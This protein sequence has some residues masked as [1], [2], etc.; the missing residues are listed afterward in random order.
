MVDSSGFPALVELILEIQMEFRHMRVI[1][2]QEVSLGDT[3]LSINPLVFG[4]LPLGPLQAALSPDAGGRIILHALERGVNLLDAAELYQTYPHIRAG[5]SRFTG[6]VFIASKT[7]AASAQDARSHVER[8]LRELGRERID[9]FHLHGARLRDP[10]VERG[11]VLEELVKMKGEGKI[12]HVG[13]SSHYIAAVRKAA[14]IPE[15]EVVHPLINRKGLGILDGDATGMA[16]AIS[17]CSRA[18]K[19]VY[20]MKALAGGNLIADA[21]SSLR[22]VAGIEGVH[23][24]AVGMLSPEEVEANLSLFSGEPASEDLWRRLEERRRRLLIM[25]RFCKGCGQCVTACT[26]DALKM[27]DGRPSLDEG[28]CILCGYCAA[29]CPEFIIRVV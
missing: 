25:D 23:A 22:Y 28:A 1:P 9:I 26:A 17:I 16:E 15:I 13:L 18:G 7:H 2:T 27:V 10:F 12:G 29:T 21:R 4:T 14:S 24:V 20:A 6:E 19:G 8:A 3:G 11:D 5:L